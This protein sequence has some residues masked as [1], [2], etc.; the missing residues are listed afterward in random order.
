MHRQRSDAPDQC[1]VGALTRAI[2]KSLN[3]PR[4]FPPSIH[5]L[6]ICVDLVY[7]CICDSWSC[8]WARVREERVVFRIMYRRA[9]L[10]DQVS[11]RDETDAL[12]LAN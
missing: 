11:R 7:A 5:R 12:R 4:P 8:A 6:L 3:T 10:N 2:L 1:R 9:C